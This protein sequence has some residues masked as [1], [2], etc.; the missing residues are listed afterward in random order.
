[1]QIAIGEL[2]GGPI[3][4]D[5]S[6]TDALLT[7]MHFF[8]TAVDESTTEKSGM[9]F[10]LLWT[11]AE[12]ASQRWLGEELLNLH[13]GPDSMTSLRGPALSACDGPHADSCVGDCCLERCLLG[14]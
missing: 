13:F 1:M 11:Q 7:H 10:H 6:E 14:C 9:N 12:L 5:V 4:Q 8:K 2:C 3:E